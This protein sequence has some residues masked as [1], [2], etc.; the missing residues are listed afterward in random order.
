MRRASF[1]S[2]HSFR[3]GRSLVIWIGALIIVGSAVWASLRLPYLYTESLKD[4]LYD[5]SRDIQY[6]DPVDVI[7]GETVTGKGI[8]VKDPRTGN[9]VY[10]LW[11][12]VSNHTLYNEPG[13]YVYGTTTFVPSYEES[14]YLSRSKDLAEA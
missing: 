13:K 4:Y 9:V 1:R 11:S 8:W 7:A 5:S 12:D 3:S 14:V 2:F 10:Q 6:H